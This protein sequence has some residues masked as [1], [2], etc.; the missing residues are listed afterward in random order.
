MACTAWLRRADRRGYY[1]TRTDSRGYGVHDMDAVA[2]RGRS[3]V[4]GAEVA[5]AESEGHQEAEGHQDAEEEEEDQSWGGWTWSER[6]QPEHYQD[7]S[8]ANWWGSDK[9]RRWEKEEDK[10]SRDADQRQGYRSPEKSTAFKR[11]LES[12]ELSSQGRRQQQSSSSSWLPVEGR[13]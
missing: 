3:F 8:R 13:N 9:R 10:W 1:Y 6:D 7:Q 2:A 4:A 12:P 5:S 11:Q